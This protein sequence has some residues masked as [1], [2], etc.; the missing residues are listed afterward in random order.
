MLHIPL[1]S[2]QYSQNICVMY[3]SDIGGNTECLA[4]HYGEFER[5]EGGWFARAEHYGE[6]PLKL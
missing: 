3:A 2:R 6:Y 1:N 5:H 4:V